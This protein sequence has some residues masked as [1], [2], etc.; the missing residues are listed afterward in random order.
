MFKLR[1]PMMLHRSADK[2]EENFQMCLRLLFIIIINDLKTPWSLIILYLIGRPRWVPNN[3][4]KTTVIQGNYINVFNP[5]HTSYM[6]F[7]ICYSWLLND[8]IST[9]YFYLM[10]IPSRII[11]LIFFTCVDSSC[12]IFQAMSNRRLSRL[13]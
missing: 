1:L 2:Y 8:D 7:Y 9:T 4:S 11:L 10:N 5:Y 6:M 3:Q 13:R 12:Y